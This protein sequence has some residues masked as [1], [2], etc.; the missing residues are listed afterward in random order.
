MERSADY[1]FE[2]CIRYGWRPRGR[3]GVDRPL[4][5]GWSYRRPGVALGRPNPDRA[6]GVVCVDASP[7]G[8]S[9]ETG[10]WV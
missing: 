7:V 9:G 6:V 1:S 8:L 5:V 2:A 3:G 4:L 10:R